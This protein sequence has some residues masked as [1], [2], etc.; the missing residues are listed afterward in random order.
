MV[1]LTRRRFLKG[2]LAAGAATALS[3][4]RVLG[5]NEAINMAFIGLG[6]RGSSSA[7][8]FSGIPGV[9][10]AGLADP[11]EGR[12]GACQKK[13]P[14]AKAV[15]DM[16][17][18]FDDKG[19]HAVCIST[20]NHWHALAAVWACQAGKDVYVEKPVS[21]SVWEG[22]MMVEAA[23]KHQRIVQ[24]G[25]QQRSDPFQKELRAWLDEGHLGKMKY[26]RLN[27]YGLR[28]SIGRRE[29]PLEIPDSIDYDLWLGP[30][31]DQ[32]I[33]RKNLQYDWHWDWNTGNGELG[34]W[35]PHLTDD[36]RNVVFGDKV[37]LPR[38][39]VA[40]GGRFKWNDAGNTP[41]THF[42]YFDTGVVPVI[43]DVHNLPRKTG[44]NVDDVYEKRRT[45]AFLIIEC[46]NGYYAG[47][48]G[49]GAAY[50][51]D[52]KKIKGFKGNGGEGHAAN[53]IEAVRS[54]KTSDLNAP[55]EQGHYSTAWCHC[56][57]VAYRLGGA[58]SQEE[59]KARVKGYRP[60]EEV[61]DE[62][63]AHLDANE[64]DPKKADIR[65]GPVI[66]IDPDS[67]TL[68]GAC[69]TDEAKAIWTG[70]DRGWRKGYE[71]KV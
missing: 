17:R 23:R 47:G 15:K 42:I 43:M 49:G 60:W 41:N 66:E 36:C 40:G 24:A 59:A 32:P 64:I 3:A 48:R 62:F 34:N 56:G 58:Y 38:R 45:R 37:T 46:E 18:L 1:R 35:G 31:K 71:I 2:T 26:V 7:G 57:N 10:V 33:Y 30:A 6:G 21:W 67:Q 14:D 51:L 44:E 28:G 29:T 27:R 52:G 8:W 54:R 19:I 39:C 5:A 20:C 55:I 25:T 16:R 4:S 13:W 53:F 9:R 68:T 70:E 50:D 61:I 11:E 12:L 69:A 65:L 22:R 63:H